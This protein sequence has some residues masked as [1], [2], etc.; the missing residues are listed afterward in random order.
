M[1]ARRRLPNRCPAPKPALAEP[2]EV[3][4]SFAN[5]KGDIVVIALRQ[6]EGAPFLDIRKFF[7]DENGIV[8][9]RVCRW[10]SSAHR[11]TA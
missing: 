8:R 3:K 4:T 7:T 5:C 6:L 9:P 10:R 11:T 2:V 1:S